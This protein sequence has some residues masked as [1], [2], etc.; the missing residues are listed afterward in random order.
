MQKLLSVHQFTPA[1]N[2][3][4]W[5]DSFYV[6]L[7]SEKYTSGKSNF[8]KAFF[9]GLRSNRKA[10]QNASNCSSVTYIAKK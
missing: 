10:L 6:S 3:P 8:I 2:K 5:F 1:G 7:L 4:M 9:N